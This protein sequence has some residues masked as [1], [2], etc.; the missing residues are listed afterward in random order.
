MVFKPVVEWKNPLFRILG[1]L[2]LFPFSLFY[3]IFAECRNILYDSGFF[4]KHTFES[5]IIGVGSLSVGGSGK[6]PLAEF[7][8]I[9]LAQ[10]GVRVGVISN[11]YRKTSRGT[12]IVTDGKI[13]KETVSRSGDE[14]T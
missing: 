9:Q 5:F 10:R 4:R 7:L 13:I 12:V 1:Y 2:L 8:A 14:A 11:G 3:G 6:T